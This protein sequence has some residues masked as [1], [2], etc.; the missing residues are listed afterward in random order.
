MKTLIC[1][2]DSITAGWDGVSEQPTL[3]NRLKNGLPGWTVHNAGVPGNN[4]N[5][6]LCRIREDVLNLAFDRVTVLF[7]ANDASI[8]KG[9]PVDE[10]ERN[11]ASIAAAVSPK[12]T[13]LITPAPVNEFKQ[14]NKTD[15]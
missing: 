14:T 4:T 11:I 10:F 6:A 3:T 5:D 13:L 9:I 8:H 2:G 7:G 15:E 1:F 12:K